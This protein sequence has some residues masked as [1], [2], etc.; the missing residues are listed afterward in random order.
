M[1]PVPFF[2]LE[3]DRSFADQYRGVFEQTGLVRFK[4]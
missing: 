4:N 2:S 3:A 1:F